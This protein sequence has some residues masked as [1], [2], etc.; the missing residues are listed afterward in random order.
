MIK[1]EN[2][3]TLYNFRKEEEEAQSSPSAAS[4]HSIFVKG[5]PYDASDQEIFNHFRHCGSIRRLSVPR[6]KLNRQKS[7]GYAF[8]EFE[9]KLSVE[10]AL[11]F[12]NTWF[13]ERYI[14]VMRNGHHRLMSQEHNTQNRE[15]I[16]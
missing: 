6:N 9:L 12:N 7:R 15:M 11:A 1:L 13:Q 5:L 8:I 2:S 4:T 16:P 3:H 10:I 14:K